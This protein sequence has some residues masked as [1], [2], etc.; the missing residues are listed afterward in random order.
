MMVL[1]GVVKMRKHNQ[2]YITWI[3]HRIECRRAGR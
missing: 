3:L 2:Q 1:C